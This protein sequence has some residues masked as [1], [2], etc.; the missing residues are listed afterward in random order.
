MNIPLFESIVDRDD[1]I[2]FL[3]VY[4]SQIDQPVF[5]YEQYQVQFSSEPIHSEPCLI[6]EKVDADQSLYLR[7]GN[8]CRNRADR[9][10]SYLLNRYANINE[11]DHASAYG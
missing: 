8:P 9:M 4:A 5:R 6:F 10:K 11:M 2:F 1:L 3:S 7:V